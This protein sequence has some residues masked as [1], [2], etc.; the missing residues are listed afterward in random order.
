MCGAP[1]TR[2]GEPGCMYDAPPPHP[3][4]PRAPASSIHKTQTESQLRSRGTA[5]VGAAVV[6]DTAHT[7]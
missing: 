2:N 5:V 7:E 1:L 6:G 4:A 3:S